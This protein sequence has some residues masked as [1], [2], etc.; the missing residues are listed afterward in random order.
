[1]GDTQAKLLRHIETLQTQ[2]ALASEN[3]Q[4]IE[5]SLESRIAALE[6]E[7]DE[8][9]RHE[10]ETRRKARDSSNAARRLQDELDSTLRKS[11]ILEQEL[12]EQRGVADKLQARATEFETQLRDARE[13]FEREKKGWQNSLTIRIEDEKTKWQQ[14]QPRWSHTES[15]NA[16]PDLSLPPPSS[17]KT[18]AFER[19]TFPL[20]RNM[21]SRF[22]ASELNMTNIETRPLSRRSSSMRLN[23]ADWAQPTPVWEHNRSGSASS[24]VLGQTPSIH[25]IDQ[26]E[27]FEDGASPHRTVNDMIS[28]STVAAGPSVQLV[29]RMSATVRRLESE[30]AASKDELARL[31]TQRDEA[32]QEV[33]SLMREVE[34]KRDVNMQARKYEAELAIVKQRYQTTLEMLGEKSEEVEEFKSDIA[35]LKKMYRELVDTTMK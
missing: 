30:K 1:M 35:D 28:V 15:P 14:E 11:K 23:S 34:E 13:A 4:G 7:K 27:L 6:A 19:P 24:P 17:R 26:D 32:R 20:R 22:I 12:L 8:A 31:S 9:S 2:Y 33:V 18:S 29:E 3:W 25:T 10:V 5:N 21:S 16:S